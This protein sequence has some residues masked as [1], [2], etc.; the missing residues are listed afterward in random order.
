MLLPISAIPCMTASRLRLMDFSL[1]EQDD[2]FLTK[3]PPKVRTEV[4]PL[5]SPI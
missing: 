1:W 2:T 4:R 3:T 5:V